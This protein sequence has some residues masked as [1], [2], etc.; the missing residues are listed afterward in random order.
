VQSADNALD[1]HNAHPAPDASPALVL[2]D[3]ERAQDA[4]VSGDDGVLAKA[5]GGA[6]V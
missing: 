2:R 4:G 1:D 3:S 6:D 5:T